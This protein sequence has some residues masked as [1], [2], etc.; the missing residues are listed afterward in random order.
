MH[1]TENKMVNI[2]ILAEKFI[3]NRKPLK[4]NVKG[5]KIGKVSALKHH[6]PTLPNSH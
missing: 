5:K 2:N 3:L 4:R 1:T 6:W